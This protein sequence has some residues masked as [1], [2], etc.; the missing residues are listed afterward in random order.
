MAHVFAF[1]DT[2][3]SLKCVCGGGGGGRLI[4]STNLDNLNPPPPMLR[5]CSCTSCCK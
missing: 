5:A 4:N 1:Y 2:Y 3:M